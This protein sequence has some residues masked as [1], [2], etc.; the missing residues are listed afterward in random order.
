[1]KNVT[2]HIFTGNNKI[3]YFT[4]RMSNMPI[5]HEVKFKLFNDCDNRYEKTHQY[6]EEVE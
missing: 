4:W 6:E 3:R 1:M 5:M 2:Q